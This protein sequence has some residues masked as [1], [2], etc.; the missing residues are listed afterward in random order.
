MKKIICLLIL[1]CNVNAFAATLDSFRNT[2]W[3]DKQIILRIKSDLSWNAVTYQGFSTGIGDSIT[4]KNNTLTFLTANTESAELTV[5]GDQINGFEK[6][7]NF[8]CNM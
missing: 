1:F 2:C 3:T 4:L 6:V 7:D 5:D 8:D